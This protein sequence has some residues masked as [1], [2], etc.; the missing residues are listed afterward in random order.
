MEIQ[1]K[2]FF[3]LSN[4][5]L[6]RGD[7]VRGVAHVAERKQ[8]AMELGAARAQLPCCLKRL[9][10][11]SYIGCWLLLKTSFALFG[12]LGGKSTDFEPF[13]GGTCADYPGLKTLSRGLSGVLGASPRKML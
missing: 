6:P 12:D 9:T 3:L 4:D 13:G 5:S 7:Q 1:W 11:G 2:Y 10:V 8:Y